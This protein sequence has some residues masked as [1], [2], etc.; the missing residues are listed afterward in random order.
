M[1]RFHLTAWVLLLSFPTPGL[2]AIDLDSDSDGDGL[3]DHQEIHKYRTRADAADSDGDGKLDGDWDERR[4]FAYTIR[5]VLRVMPP[6]NEAHLCDDYQDARVRQRTDR[7][8]EVEAIHYPFNTNDAT[9]GETRDWQSVARQMPEYTRPG[10]T[11]NWDDGMRRDLLKAMADAGIELDGLSDR[12]TVLRVARWA[13]RVARPRDNFNAFH[14]HYPGGVPTVVPGREDAVKGDM[15]D[16]A[17]T[18]RQQFEHELLGREMFYNRCRGTCTSTAVYLTT[19]LRAVGIPTR[20]IVVTPFVDGSDGE[21]AALA[22]RAIQDPRVRPTILDALERLRGANASHTFNEVFVGGRWRRLN[23]DKLGQNIFDPGLFGL[24]T[25]VH[26]FNDL[27]EA[28]LWKWGGRKPDEVFAHQ[29]PYSAVEVSEQTGRHHVPRAVDAVPAAAPSPAP[30]Q[31]KLRA[32]KVSKVRWLDAPDLP[33]RVRESEFARDGSGHLFLHVEEPGADAAEYKA[34]YD[35]AAK[36]F[37][38]VAKGH[39]TVKA[40]AE[41]GYWLDSSADCREFYLRIAPDEMKKLRD[42]VAYALEVV[43][44]RD[45]ARWIVAA[46]LEMRRTRAAAGPPSLSITRVRW[47]EDESLPANVRDGRFQA[48]GSGHLF[49]HAE[50]LADDNADAYARFY[51]AAPKEFRLRAAG[52]ADVLVRAERGYW[53]DPSQDCREFYARVAPDEMKKIKPG[54]EYELVPAAGEAGAAKWSIAPKVRV[55]RR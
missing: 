43:G 25:H 44:Q 23:G 48:D 10:V 45:D 50:K 16:P 1:S 37:R 36:Q 20:M 22:R 2:A 40:Q 9:I 7:F 30:V 19:V 14:V 32:L 27:S 3:S 24:V 13:L 38:F 6:V 41:R 35:T 29:N 5:T 55:T 33:Q 11:T 28:E 31:G 21:N 49:L 8:V 54:V 17:W 34:F 15:G 51:Q 42:D 4:E 52:H 18:F 47:L 39:P 26:T 12:D 53:I 46:G